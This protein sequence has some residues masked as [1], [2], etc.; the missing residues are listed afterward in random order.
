[1]MKKHITMALVAIAAFAFSGCSN[2]DIQ[3]D[4]SL[5]VTINPAGVVAPFTF[6]VY[7]GDLTYF[8]YKYTL[9]TR[10]L[11]YN[12]VGKRVALEERRLNDYNDI[13]NVQPDLP[14]GTYTMIAITDVISKDGRTEYWTLS[15]GDGHDLDKLQVTTVKEM[16]GENAVIVQGYKRNILGTQ[17]KRVTIN[18]E[19]KAINMEPT[20]AGALLCVHIN[21]IKKFSDVKVLQFNT[22][23]LPD[24]ISFDTSKGDFVASSRNLGSQLRGVFVNFLPDESNVDFVDYIFMLP[25]DAIL[26]FAYRE[27]D[28]K[29]HLV[30]YKD[31]AEP[32]YLSANLVQGK[33][34]E[35]LLDLNSMS[36][37]ATGKSFSIRAID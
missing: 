6:E 26:A 15:D 28:N 25:T 27:S 11:I 29:A 37:I 35:V 17:V 5:T 1:M 33:E 34:Y 2:E 21:G 32:R 3:I 4:K 22:N 7:S 18:K 12:E 16:Q 14:N 30:G 19:T 13:M 31:T 23:Q 20:A 9:R 36:D 8:D 24:Y 10:L